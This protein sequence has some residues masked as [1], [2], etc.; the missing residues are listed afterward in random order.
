MSLFMN[1]DMCFSF[2]TSDVFFSYS[3]E[4]TVYIQHKYRRIYSTDR[5]LQYISVFVRGGPVCVWHFP[6]FSHHV[7]LVFF[8]YRMKRM[9]YDDERLYTL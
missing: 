9:R 2:F 8:L 6:H 7:Y 3:Q 1:F 4:S 5:M